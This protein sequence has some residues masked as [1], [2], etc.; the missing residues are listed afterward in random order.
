MNYR[1]F[2]EAMCNFQIPKDYEIHHIDFDRN[3][4]KISNLVMLPAFL[5]KKYHIKLSEYKE[6]SCTLT[7]E[8]SGYGYGYGFNEFCLKEKYRV[9]KEFVDIW[10]EC[11]KYVSY[12]DYQLGKSIYFPN[13]KKIEEEIYGKNKST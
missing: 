12:R 11:A 13:F 6:F 2:Y 9:A 4:N 1:K 5:H 7:E 10:Y 3:N 8:L